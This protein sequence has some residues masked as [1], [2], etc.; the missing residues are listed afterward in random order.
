[1]TRKITPA[2]HSS[3]LRTGK[4]RTPEHHAHLCHKARA[5]DLVAVGSAWVL[6]LVAHDL[7]RFDGTVIPTLHPS[8]SARQEWSPLTRT[9]RATLGVMECQPAER[10]SVSAVHRKLV[11]YAA[12]WPS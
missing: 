8:F 3:V 2:S 9:L 12:Y 5:G 6:Q 1:M 11:V 10:N 7:P 4:P